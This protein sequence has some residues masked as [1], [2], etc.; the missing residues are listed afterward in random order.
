MLKVATL[1]VVL[2]KIN[3]ITI[4]VVEIKAMELVMLITPLIPIEL[5]SGVCL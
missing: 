5:L 4:R 3:S 1:V 2:V